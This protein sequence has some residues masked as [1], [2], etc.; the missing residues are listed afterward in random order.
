MEEGDSYINL[1]DPYD[2]EKGEQYDKDKLGA[3]PDNSGKNNVK[4]WIKIMGFVNILAIL[5]QLI[6]VI[7]DHSLTNLILI[8]N[9]LHVIILPGLCILTNS[10][11]IHKWAN[12]FI[13][14]CIITLILDSIAFVFRLVYNLECDTGNSSPTNF[15]HTHQAVIWIEL[16][17]SSLLLLIVLVILILIYIHE[18]WFKPKTIDK[19]INI[20]SEK[21]IKTNISDNSHPQ[22][23][24]Y[25]SSINNRTNNTTTQKNN[26]DQ[27][28]KLWMKQ[29]IQAG[30]TKQNKLNDN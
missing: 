26:N 7:F 10:I 14:W 16:V 8:L 22:N 13:W 6:M 1:E 15:C 28:R 30:Q 29:R 5:G 19:K 3:I 11:L 24:T 17:F 25:N 27:A 20:K 4:L 21:K 2:V 23:A 18:H 9:I 12:F